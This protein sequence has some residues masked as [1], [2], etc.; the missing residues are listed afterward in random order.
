[1]T[2]AE[3][4]LRVANT[5]VARLKMS[6]PLTLVRLPMPRETQ[7]A[8]INPRAPAFTPFKKLR[9]TG[10]RRNIGMSGLLSSTKMKEGRKIPMVA[11]MAP[12]SPSRS[13]PMNVAVDRMVPGVKCPIEIASRRCFCVSH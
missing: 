8:S 4:R 12:G 1:M 10:E 7:T 3:L 2:Q 9:A 11:T 5:S 13:Y 6:Q